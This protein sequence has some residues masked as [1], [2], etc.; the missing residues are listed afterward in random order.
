MLLSFS[1]I[2]ERT[3]YWLQD[4]VDW[5]VTSYGAL[6]NNKY[7][8][9]RVVQD[10]KVAF[11]NQLMSPMTT[12]DLSGDGLFILGLDG[13]VNPR[14]L[15]LL[16]S[17]FYAKEL[18]AR[19]VG[20][21][22][23]DI[24]NMNNMIG[25]QWERDMNTMVRSFLRISTLDC[26]RIMGFDD[27][28]SNSTLSALRA[29]KERIHGLMCTS[30]TA[31]EDKAFLAA[32]EWDGFG[33]L[34]ISE[35][36]CPSCRWQIEEMSFNDYLAV[37]YRLYR[38]GVLKILISHLSCLDVEEN[39]APS[40]VVHQNGTDTTDQVFVIHSLF[41]HKQSSGLRQ[42]TIYIP[43]HL[44]AFFSKSALVASSLLVASSFLVNIK[45]SNY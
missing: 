27:K 10:A 19:E 9:L 22:N 21:E 16:G 11:E 8:T 1:Q 29:I 18:L 28:F 24:T 32:A 25:T 30:T 2:D 35:S 45:G 33:G 40:N 20:R 38:K 39:I 41:V 5:Y 36:G 37:S 6:N 7:L 15:C 31:E 42:Y 26:E 34:G 23:M 17:L 14:I 12:T 3:S 13:S 4:L 43:S 44:E